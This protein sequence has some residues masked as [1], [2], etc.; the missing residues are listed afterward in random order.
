MKAPWRIVLPLLAPLMLCASGCHIMRAISKRECHE[1]QP[2]MKATSVP[3]LQIPPGLD[4]PDT[5]NAL[6][7]PV[8]NEP[9]PP[10][11]GKSDPCLD[12]P[13]SF[14]VQRQPPRTPQA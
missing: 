6:R 3:P 5:T 4:A 13:P 1:P 9:A 8:L 7:L 10:P 12:E 11:R 2:Y 14:K